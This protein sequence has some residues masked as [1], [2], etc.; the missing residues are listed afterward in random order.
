MNTY[1]HILLKALL[2]MMAVISTTG[3][4][5]QTETDLFYIRFTNRNSPGVGAYVVVTD[6]GLGNALT[7]TTR[8]NN[9]TTTTDAAK[10]RLWQWVD[11]KYLRNL[12]GHYICLDGTS[13]KTT[14]D[15]AL[16]TPFRVYYNYRARPKLRVLNADG[17]DQDLV[18][19]A[20]TVQ[21]NNSPVVASANLT[22][23]DDELELSD[24]Y[25]K[26]GQKYFIRFGTNYNSSFIHEMGVAAPDD[27][28]NGHTPTLCVSSA[29]TAGGDKVNGNNTVV[30]P[31]LRRNMTWT[32][33]QNGDNYRISSDNG[34]YIG[35]TA[36]VN[37]YGGNNNVYT[38]TSQAAEAAD[39]VVR[40]RTNPN[41]H[42]LGLTDTEHP[43]NSFN[44]H[45]DRT[46]RY[47][48]TWASANIA[49]KEVIDFVRNDDPLPQD[50]PTMQE[51]HWYKLTFGG[52]VQTLIKAHV[53]ADGYYTLERD[54]GRYVS[55]TGTEYVYTTNVADAAKFEVRAERTGWHLER[56]SNDI[57]V[58]VTIAEGNQ[59]KEVYH[60]RKTDN[61][62]QADTW[63]SFEEVE[64]SEHPTMQDGWYTLF[65]QDVPICSKLVTYVG[66]DAG[67]NRMYTLQ[68]GDNYIKD[69]P[70]WDNGKKW[71]AYTT[72][73]DPA[74]AARFVITREFHGW[75]LTRV[76]DDAYGRTTY[77][78]VDN[79]GTDSFREI[80]TRN[81]YTFRA[82]P[83][84][85][86]LEDGAKY[87]FYFK[88][89]Q[90][91]GMYDREMESGRDSE[92]WNFYPGQR[93]GAM[94]WTAILTEEGGQRY[95]SFKNE[96]DRYI[97]FNSS[98][99]RYYITNDA[100][101]ATQFYL[102]NGD[103]GANLVNRATGNVFQQT[104]NSRFNEKAYA[105]MSDSEKQWAAIYFVK[106]TTDDAWFFDDTQDYAVLHR[107]SYYQQR[108]NELADEGHHFTGEFMQPGEGMTTRTL[109]GGTEV[110]TQDVPEYRTT[111]YVRRGDFV[112][113]YLS[114]NN[115]DNDD[116]YHR[117]FQRWYLYDSEQP[118]TH[119]YFLPYRNNKTYIYQNGLV[120]G[121]WLL[122]SDG[123][124]LALK[125]YDGSYA[126]YVGRSLIGRLPTDE[127]Q[128]T[129]ACDFSFRNSRNNNETKTDLQYANGHALTAAEAGD[130]TE[131]TLSLRQIWTLVDAKVMANR[132]VQQTGD[133]NWLEQRTIHFS[134]RTQGLSKEY[135]PIEYALEDYW[136]YRNYTGE[137]SQRTDANLVNMGQ[138]DGNNRDRY[139]AIEAVDHGSGV[140]VDAT[141]KQLTKATNNDYFSN[142]DWT[143]RRLLSFNYPA[144]RHVPAD[145]SI[146]IMVYAVDNTAGGGNGNRYNVAKFTIIFDANSQT[147][148]YMDIVGDGATHPDRS[149]QTLRENCGTPRAFL[150]FDYDNS[151]PFISPNYNGQ[152]TLMSA[153]P[154]DYSKTNYGFARRPKDEIIGA[155]WGCFGI[156]NLHKVKAGAG[157][158][159][160]KFVAKSVSQYTG[161][162]YYKED[163]PNYALYGPGFF[164]VDASDLPGQ[165]ASVSFTGDFCEG[166][167]L[168]CTGWI[169]SMQGGWSNTSP[170]SVVLTMM[171]RKYNTT[172]KQYEET[173][174]YTFCPGQ[175][176]YYARR[177]DTYDDDNNLT[178][179]GGIIYPEDN[180][181][182]GTAENCGGDY[183]WQQFYFEFFG[184]GSDEYY[185]R[186]DNNATST[187]GGDYA[188]D[189]IW[190]FATLPSIETGTI[191]PLCGGETELVQVEND[192][193]TLLNAVGKSEWRQGEQEQ[194][195]YLSLTYLDWEKFVTDFKAKVEAAE[196]TT[197]TRDEFVT[198]LNQGT[199]LNYSQST[200]YQEA[201]SAALMTNI[202][203]QVSYVNLSWSNRF[204]SP[205]KHTPYSFANLYNNRGDASKVYYHT[206][207][208]GVRKLVFN[209]RMDIDK[210]E[211]YHEYVLL[212]AILATPLQDS[213]RNR[214]YNFFNV[215][216]TCSTR[217]RLYMQPFTEVNGTVGMQ[218]LTELS[219]C[220]NTIETLSL[221][222]KALRLD[223]ETGELVEDTNGE[224]AFDWWVG[225]SD[226]PGTISNFNAQ[227]SGDGPDDVTLQFALKC[228]RYNYPMVTSLEGLAVPVTNDQ[229]PDYTLTADILNYLKSLTEPAD[230]SMPQLYLRSKTVNVVLDSRNIKLVEEWN[231]NFAYFCALPIESDIDQGHQHTVY[232]CSM[233]QQVK[234]RVDEVAPHIDL[235]FSDKAYPDKLD[236]LSVRIAKK[237]FEQVNARNAD[238][239]CLHIPLRNVDSQSENAIGIKNIGTTEGDVILLT[240]TTDTEMEGYLLS[241]V[242]NSG[243]AVVGTITHLYGTDGNTEEKPEEAIALYFHSDFKVREGYSYTLKF[244]Y[245]ER[246]ADEAEISTRCEGYGAFIMKIV[247]DYEV[248]T[249]EAGNIDW[250]NDDNW[251]RADYDE[252]QAANGT[253]LKD[254]YLWNG[255]VDGDGDILEAASNQDGSPR[256]NYITA[257]DRY[258]RRGFAPLYCTN[259]LMMTSET[260]PAPI[261]YDNG[262]DGDT[263]FPL[264]EATA[265]PMLRYDF[266][267]HTWPI[268]EDDEL[269]NAAN[270]FDPTDMVRHEGDIVTEL[271][272]SNVC[273]GIVFQPE[274]ELVHAEILNYEKAWVEFALQKDIWSLVG[275]P[276]KNTISG[277]WYAPTYSARQETTYYEP[278]QF[279][280]KP[281]SSIKHYDAQGAVVS[282]DTYNLGYDRFAPAV[283]QRAWDKAKAV[284]Y[285]RGAVWSPDDGNQEDDNL[286]DDGMGQWQADPQGE[287][288]TWEEDLNA[289]DYLNRLV[290]KPM[291]DSKVN[292]AIRGSW[293]G[294]YNDHTVPYD[295][296]GFSVM[297]I[298]HF[299]TPHNDD[300][301]KAVF[302]MPKEDHFYD[303]WDWGKSYRLNRRVRVYIKDENNPWPTDARWRDSITTANTV[304]LN[305]RGRLR[306][307]DL[308]LDAPT[309]EVPTPQPK[310]Y[311]VTLK[312]EGQGS[313]GFF[314]ACNPFICGLDMQKFFAKNTNLAPYYL[315]LKDSEIATDA[316][317]TPS[318]WKWT[319][320]IINGNNGTDSF[321]GLQVVPARRGFFVRAAEGGN[322]NE[323]SVTF[324]T[325]MMTTAR[326][327]VSD[328]SG[329]GT[330]PSRQYL[331]IRAQRDGNISE[332]RVAIT[333]NASNTFCPE[334]DLETFLVSDI[335]SD[336][337][338]VYTL[339][340]C[341]AT[342][343]NH[344]RHFNS[345][346]LGIISNSTDAATLTFYGVESIDS[347]LQLYDAYLQTF[348]PLVSGI[349]VRVPGSTQNRFF[350]VTS[351]GEEA[352][353]E[354]SIQI[355]PVQGGVQ[356]TSVTGEPLTQVFAYDMAGRIVAR[357][358]VG[359]PECLLSLPK[360]AY[361]V[362]AETLSH[363]QTKKVIVDQ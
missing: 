274:T 267:G 284:L 46:P 83:L 329:S 331:T 179:E 231:G 33:E 80:D 222:I 184:N 28:Y 175:V 125:K 43:V 18:M 350:L 255:H 36:V 252:L 295:G 54:M 317:L 143:R 142:T 237:Q 2:L 177:A 91:R 126:N 241:H 199:F 358:D 326:A 193:E 116:T 98:Q 338:V 287:G 138:V 85:Y 149:P 353:A 218:D 7:M 209:G 60:N 277:E 96:F 118:L 346:P 112:G 278:V 298:N 123:V 23:T 133:D 77:A 292:V 29:T 30:Y 266:Q 10:N 121:N 176:S 110:T 173:E 161:I 357:A 289:N 305:Y 308:R 119:K 322:L 334:E 17:T 226:T 152:E 220:M 106:V 155:D 205:T 93:G 52:T 238:H 268:D 246:F 162:S 9:P 71:Y 283:Y 347:N 319:D 51:G 299:K 316:E 359:Q 74:E 291:G 67:G 72:T 198:M 32:L 115:A 190:V 309:T 44:I 337:P 296:G 345:L 56:V 164:Y 183:I 254:S 336:I 217:V 102:Q 132:L 41:D 156:G 81:S 12:Q 150:N 144:T 262:M 14:D 315:V 105:S 127:E 186:I 171:G 6:N 213:D 122:N 251:R 82:E 39:I 37:C 207:R 192:F 273:D 264:L 68:Y 141:F 69:A 253:T 280:Y 256:V 227:K 191:L 330:D 145:S 235:G 249:G 333:P 87:V 16:A 182:Y 343:I 157:D 47:V 180:N 302:R 304:E 294:A 117:G 4:T 271:Y 140:T 320:V 285:E 153:L 40:I 22:A 61:S 188:L 204:D 45:A 34:L 70:T 86:D 66:L 20:Q 215:L 170:G 57:N 167:K 79:N 135:I 208:E 48:I 113:L 355:L 35:K 212:A 286:G 166:S 15:A 27:T 243:G 245:T 76:N 109:N 107:Q 301:E 151:I 339:T 169:A 53:D 89:N 210:F 202:D 270:P 272:T 159:E 335:S 363:Q 195:G 275:S 229:Y 214:F 92:L 260:A 324:T 306:S 216:S 38:I 265:S 349:S 24:Y 75:Q 73:T 101:A 332:A 99:N 230:G 307:D 84:P 269:N 206:N 178:A 131:P 50:V 104:G 300:A 130:L 172:T 203:G 258:R 185:V 313:L 219:H 88:N 340:G 21:T 362:K 158:H 297:P 200:T 352:V 65:F 318:T 314:L 311:T 137:E 194:T 233:P 90:L 354:S 221:N 341:L 174:V 244:P 288:F 108:A 13:F 247:P 342:S 160:M 234:L 224:A 293:S 259:I 3:M 232:T 64:D 327:T 120:M 114:T 124:N 163:D 276:L 59:F 97:T 148:P 351:I 94:A 312:N 181:V 168:I 31:P 360:G 328:P 129:I 111:H 25:P 146:D 263:G 63:F 8:G 139:Y 248:W 261:L 196:N 100:S 239:T 5:A 225:D 228:L 348:T 321:S 240:A 11:G 325:D 236:L 257:A 165:I 223:D 344:L 55:W 62:N 58:K 197:Y 128:V 189:D 78:T 42:W 323:T 250:S 281:V 290:Y 361:A 49:N 201:F 19:R 282:A 26:T 279:D 242:D 147:L 95:F 303:I 134:N 211:Y 310:E 103:Y 356:V 187:T 154:L 1:S 136:F